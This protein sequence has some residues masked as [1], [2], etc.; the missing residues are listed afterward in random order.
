METVYRHNWYYDRPVDTALAHGEGV[1]VDENGVDVTTV[2]DLFTTTD[3]AG[4]FIRIGSNS[5]LYEIASWT[6]TSAI[7]LVDDFRGD[8]V[9]GTDAYFEIRP[10]GQTKRMNFCDQAKAAIEPTYIKII[11][12]KE[13]LPIWNDYDIMLLPGNAEAVRMKA[14]QNLLRRTG[15]IRESRMMGEEVRLV[16]NSTNRQA[17]AGIFPFRPKGSFKARKANWG[18]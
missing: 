2:G 7:T 6:S 4:E 18:V 15:K 5:G 11:Y 8:D 17:Q 13:P 14:L 3:C 16:M 1:N 12:Y 9:T 10:V